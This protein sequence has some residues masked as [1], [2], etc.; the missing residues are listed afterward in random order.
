[1]H[2]EFFTFFRIWESQSLCYI[3]LKPG[4]PGARTESNLKKIKVVKNSADPVISNQ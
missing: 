3:V 4:W 2:I 1:M